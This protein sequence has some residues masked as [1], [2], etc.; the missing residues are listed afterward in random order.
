[1]MNPAEFANIARAEKDLWWYRGTREILFRMLDP[2]IKDRKFGRVLEAGCGTGYMSAVL[3]ERY[4]WPMYP[5]DLGWEGL[6]YGKRYGIERMTQ[7]DMTAL[8]FAD[9]SFDAV[10]SLDVIVHLP[11]GE[12]WRA[13]SELARVLK[14]DGL[15]IIRVSALDILRSRHSMFAHERQRFTK[16]RL[17]ESAHKAGIRP[18]RITYCNSLLM[19]VALA[20]FRIV[21]PL[22]NKPPASGVEPVPQW[23]DSLLYAPL[24]LEAGWV[25]AGLGFP[26]GQSLV[27]LGQRL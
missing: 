23:L 5:L 26:A 9:K 18:L 11:R 3:K 25:G 13:F 6:E 19:P 1:M 4:G 2:I 15:A 27:L 24:A 16:A 21:E 20:K 22:L 17:R 7:A 10:V 12:E 14:P 8:P